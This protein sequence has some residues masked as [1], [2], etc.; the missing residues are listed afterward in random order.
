MIYSIVDPCADYTLC[1][2]KP[3]RTHQSNA[4]HSQ[5]ISTYVNDCKL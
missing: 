5:K 2:L 1:T 4:C 3:G